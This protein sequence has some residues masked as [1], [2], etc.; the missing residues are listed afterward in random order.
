MRIIW[1]PIMRNVTHTETAYAK[2]NLYLEVFDKREDGFHD[3][4]TVMQTVSLSDTLSFTVSD[5]LFTDVSLSVRGADDLSCGEDNLIVRA[6]HLFSE[7]FS[8]PLQIFVSLTKR[9][10]MQAGL[11]GGSADAA[12][13]LRALAK[14]CGIPLTHPMLHRCAVALGSDVPFCLVGG[15]ALCHGRGEK[16]EIIPEMK[17]FLLLLANSGER[18]STPTAFGALDAY[19]AEKK[20][21]VSYHPPVAQTVSAVREGD[22]NRLA[23]SLYN[24]FE[25]VVL[26]LCP[27]A[28]K[29]RTEMIEKGALAALM[30]GS[31]A[32]IYGLFASESDA[33]KV[34]ETLSFPSFLVRTVD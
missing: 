31:G 8:R 18:V 33:E 29:M 27:R 16:M 12:A 19:R 5:S 9:I 23:N 28:C 4:E 32:T 13:T 15:S 2:I 6:A 34:Q 7:A 30:S 17:V 14:V 26:P 21:A 10:P 11:A 1:Y 20:G 24:C 25:Q 22:A 3:V